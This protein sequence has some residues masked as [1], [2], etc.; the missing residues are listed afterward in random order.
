M[1]KTILIVISL[2]LAGSFLNSKHSPTNAVCDRIVDRAVE[3]VSQTKATVVGLATDVK[4]EVVATN[5]K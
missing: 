2:L 3:F 1:F 5:R 4:T